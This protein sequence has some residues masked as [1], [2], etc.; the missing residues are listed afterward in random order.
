MKCFLVILNVVLRN[1]PQLPTIRWMKKTMNTGSVQS[2]LDSRLYIISMHTPG[3][4]SKSLWSL[5]PE[6]DLR[7][8]VPST[9]KIPPCF[10]SYHLNPIHPWNSCSNPTSSMSCFRTTLTKEVFHTVQLLWLVCYSLGP[11]HT[12]MDIHIVSSM[13]LYTPSEPD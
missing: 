3:T 4:K 13:P 8:F 10:L 7:R 6:H 11:L 2:C 1:L 12:L 9:Y 5:L